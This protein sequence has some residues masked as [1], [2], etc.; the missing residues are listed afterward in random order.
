MPARGGSET[1]FLE[2][3]GTGFDLQRNGVYFIDARDD[4]LKFFDFK[5]HMV[6][7]ITALSGSL[8][9]QLSISPDEHWAL[10]VNLA[11]VG[12]ELMLVEN[13]R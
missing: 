9:E 8:S 10:Y 1:K 12:S 7:T 4:G 13:F 6:K 5:A 3:A 2:Y 11:R